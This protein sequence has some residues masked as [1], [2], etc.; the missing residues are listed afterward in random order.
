[1]FYELPANSKVIFFYIKTWFFYYYR[2]LS[3]RIFTIFQIFF[4][5]SETIVTIKKRLTN[6]QL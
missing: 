2:K 6:V 1:M 3:E 4:E 5:R